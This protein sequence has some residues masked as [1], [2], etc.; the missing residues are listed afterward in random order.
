MERRS[1]LSNLIEDWK[2][3]SA[4][5]RL[6]IFADSTTIITIVTAPAVINALGIGVSFELIPFYLGL[7]WLFLSTVLGV[8]LIHTIYLGLKYFF[9]EYK[10]LLIYIRLFVVGLIFIGILAIWTYAQILIKEFFR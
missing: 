8:L 2:S 3:G 7:G 10:F 6:G 1:F 9:S 4:A 5:V